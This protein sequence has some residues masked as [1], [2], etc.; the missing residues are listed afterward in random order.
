MR[1]AVL[2]LLLL[3]LAG[4]TTPRFRPAWNASDTDMAKA[5][6]DCQQ[7]WRQ[8]YL[9]HIAVNP[10]YGGIVGFKKRSFIIDCMKAHGY[11]VAE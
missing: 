9:T 8:N 6:W 5:E 2:L 3:V 1:Q 7:Q 4:C 10:Q 11:E